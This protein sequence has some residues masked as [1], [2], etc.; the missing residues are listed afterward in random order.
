MI[1]ERPFR[2]IVLAVTLACILCISSPAQ[3]DREVVFRDYLIAQERIDRCLAAASTFAET[4]ACAGLAKRACIDPNSDWPAPMPRDCEW[5]EMPFWEVIYQAEVMRKLRWGQE[6]DAGLEARLYS[7]D[8]LLTVMRGELAWRAY[9]I[10]QCSFEALPDV[11]K[12]YEYRIANDQPCMERMFAERIFYLRSL[13][14]MIPHAE[15]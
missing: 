7:G 12:S 8:A 10:S 1:S 2:A 13:T 11:E 15:R 9:A 6:F 4:G 5:N 3:A 14:N